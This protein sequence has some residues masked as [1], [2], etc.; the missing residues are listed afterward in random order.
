MVFEATDWSSLPDMTPGY[1]A[2]MFGPASPLSVGLIT[3]QDGPS[4]IITG[5]G[6]AVTA[7]E[8]AAT[9]TLDGNCATANGEYT[10]AASAVNPKM[11]FFAGLRSPTPSYLYV[12]VDVT[13]DMTNDLVLD[14]GELLFDQT[15]DGSSTPDSNDRLFRVASGGAFTSMEWNGIAWVVCGASCDSGDDAMGHF[16]ATNEVYEFKIA[17]ADVWGPSPQSNPVAGFAIVVQD[18]TGSQTYT[19]GSASVNESNPSTWGQIQIPEF[20]DFLLVSV[21]VVVLVGIQLRRRRS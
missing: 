18:S 11:K 12:C 15:N 19:W 14:T 13:A 20:N 16:N 10:G 1:Q 2:P 8:L 7:T 6:L 17:F 9:P 5:T 21:S 4:L 3:P